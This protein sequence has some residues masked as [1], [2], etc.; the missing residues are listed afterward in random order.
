[1]YVD[2]QPLLTELGFLLGELLEYQVTMHGKPAGTIALNTKERKRVDGQDCL[3]LTAAVMSVAPGSTSLRS[4][5]LM[6]VRVDPNTLAP[7][8]YESKFSS[9]F[10]SLNQTLTFDPNGGEVG[11][12]G[13]STVDAPVGTHTILSLMYAIR[14]F[15]LKPSKDPSNPV[16]DTRVAVFWGDKPLIFTLRPSGQRRDNHRQPTSLRHN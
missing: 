9:P 1:M 4:G 6:Q 5:D 8:Y 13:K 15:N 7:K 12:G 3:L 11:T 10:A 16:N 2:N 14:S